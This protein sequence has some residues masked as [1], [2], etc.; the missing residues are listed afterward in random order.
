MLDVSLFTVLTDSMPAVSS[1]QPSAFAKTYRPCT[2]A[3]NCD[4]LSLEEVY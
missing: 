2:W 4:Y 3:F 1:R